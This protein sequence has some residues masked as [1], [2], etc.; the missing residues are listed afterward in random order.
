MSHPHTSLTI[1]FYIGFIYFLSLPSCALTR[2]S[3]QDTFEEQLLIRPL[4]NGLILSHFQFDIF[5]ENVQRE[6]SEVESYGLFPK[7]IGQI[8]DKFNVGELHLSLTQGRWLPSFGAPISPAPVG[9]ELWAWL[10]AQN[11]SDASKQWTS[12]L[13]ALSGIFCASLSEIPSS[14][15]STPIHSFRPFGSAFPED[16][17][18]HLRHGTLPREHVCT[19]NLT[20]WVKLLPCRRAAG[21]G[22]LLNPLKLFDSHFHSM[23]IHAVP[24]CSEKNGDECVQSSWRLTQTISVVQDS[25]LL[26]GNDVYG[27]TFRRLFDQRSLR[28]CPIAQ[29][30]SVHLEFPEFVHKKFPNLFA[31]AQNDGVTKENLKTDEF[32]VSAVP[33]KVVRDGTSKSIIFEY[34]MFKLDELNL[35]VQWKGTKSFIDHLVGPTSHPPLIAHRHFTGEGLQF[36]GVSVS[37]RNSDPTKSLRILYFETYPWYMRIYY[38]T[39]QIFLNGKRIDYNKDLEFFHFTPAKYHSDPSLVELITTLAPGS[40]LTL[41]FEF[42]KAFLTIDEF[43]P[44]YNR[45]FDIGSS[46]VTILPEKHSEL[47]SD[48]LGLY[49]WDRRNTSPDLDTP[50]RVYSDQLLLLLP[51]PDMSMPFNVIG[52][53]SSILAVMVGGLFNMLF[54]RPAELQRSVGKERLGFILRS[55]LNSAWA[56]ITRLKPDALV[57]YFVGCIKRFRRLLI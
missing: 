39:L 51:S 29:I 10:G 36:G 55:L 5:S 33:S 9:G 4:E 20:P 15:T 22:S 34:D 38:H 16:V 49:G 24:I 1:R 6:M 27:F 53:T 28:A 52:V 41:F 21:I 50:Y 17:S 7:S 23:Q 35:G 25:Q 43:P 14:Q 45:G 48:F 32:S 57:A 11:S 30:S 19:E 26:S 56:L 31:G 13:E 18:F 8:L 47:S 12:L 44:D 40:S 3:Q 42:E 54:R 37:I 46:V 2:E